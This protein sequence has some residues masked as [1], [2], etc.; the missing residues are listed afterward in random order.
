MLSVCFHLIE[1]H[2]DILLF[3]V[4]Y[5]H[6]SVCYLDYEIMLSFFW[7]DLIFLY[8]VI[9]QYRAVFRSIFDG[10]GEKVD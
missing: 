2:E 6:S 7:I 5:S 10:V 4:G 3:L 8:A 1:S 9:H